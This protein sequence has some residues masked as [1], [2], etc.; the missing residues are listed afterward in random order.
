MGGALDLGLYVHV[1]FCVSRC[2]YCD[3]H[4]GI[5]DGER[6]R[7]WLD[8]LSVHLAGLDLRFGKPS[9][10]TLFIGGGTPSALPRPLLKRLLALLG[11]RI[12]ASS[13]A[14]EASVEANPEDI[15]QGFLALLEDAG[16]DRLSVGVQSLE[17]AARERVNRRGKAAGTRAGLELLAA[18]WR[19][20]SSA[21]F[22]YGLPGQSA[23]GLAED[24]RYAAGLGIGHLSLYELTLADGSLL[25]SLVAS[26]RERLPEADESA[27]MYA[28]AR[29][30]LERLGFRRYEISN[31]ALPGQECR[32]NERY[33]NMESWLALGPSGSATLR[34]EGSFLR[35]DNAADD[36]RYRADPVGSAS[37][38]EVSGLDARFE[39]V[40]MGLRQ[41]K[42]FGRDAYRRFFGDHPEDS[43][44]GAL[45]ARPGLI[46]F[47]EGR[48]RPTERGMDTLNAVLVDCLREAARRKAKP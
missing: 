10:G 27:D 47:S 23:A 39:Y 36:E 13:P 18:R 4:S 14:R 22:M 28:A 2:S 7:A 11:P 37:E 32:H 40:M 5:L 9:F 26:G 30:E 8:A 6:A 44:G 41:R 20:R 15:D 29:E 45:G 35:I 3:F 12:D 42:G 21:D 31:W 24:I 38:Y 34:R 25:S 48:Y 17:D 16:V 43:F 19:G 33:W 46:E 1:P